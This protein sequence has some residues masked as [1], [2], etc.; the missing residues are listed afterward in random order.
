MERKGR[1]PGR[2]AWT[3]AGLLLVAGFAWAVVRSQAPPD[4]PRPVV[5]DRQS[6]AECGMSVSDPRFACQLQTAD[7][8]VLD[9]DDPGCLFRHLS[10]E[11]APVRAIYFHAFGEDRW[12]ARDEVGFVAVP[13]SPMGYD[14]AAVA[15]GRADAIDFETARARALAGE[16]SHAA[17]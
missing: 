7:G 9:F 13:N 10:K 15:S 3:L 11:S 1:M 16:T 2:I 4:G 17:H 14:L 12:L 5:W 8:D 6:C